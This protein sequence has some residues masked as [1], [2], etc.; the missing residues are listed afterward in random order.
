MTD[1]LPDAAARALIARVEDQRRSDLGRATRTLARGFAR[2][3]AGASPAARGELWRLRGHVL[4]AQRRAAG[5]VDA[6]LRAERWFARARQTRERGRCAIGLVDALMYLGRYRAAR[7]AA[8]RGRAA[9]ERAGDRAACARLLNNEGNLL[10]RLDRPDLALPVYRRA[11]RTLAHAGDA[12]GAAM[13][14][15][16]LANCLSLVGRLKESRASYVRAQRT[17]AANGFAV[18]ALGAGYNLAYLDFL[19]HRH[20][21]AL[22]GLAAVRE[23]AATRG[24]PALQALTSLD[25]AEILL[26]LNAPHD[27]LDEA[28]RAMDAF[29][30]LGMG[31]ERAK[32]ETFAALAEFRLGRPA[33]ARARLEHTLAGFHAEGNRVWMGEVLVGLATVWWSEGT[34]RAARALLAAA[35]RRFAAAGD[36][37]RE[38]GA[39]ALLARAQ[40]AC[41]R[42]ESAR[43]T[44]A[45]LRPRLGRRASPRVRHL[46]WAAAAA[47]ARSRGDRAAARRWLARAARES[48]RLAARIL[49]EQWR[50]T[51]WGDW[52]WPHQELATLEMEAGDFAAALEALERGRGRALASPSARAA[53][54]PAARAWAASRLARDRERSTRTGSAP[55]L[56][57]PALA[58][59]GSRL[60]DRPLS[61][62]VTARALCRVLPPGTVLVDYLLHGG[63]LSALVVRREGVDAVTGLASE[64]EVQRLMHGLLFGLRSAAW[65]DPGEEAVDPALAADLEALASQVLWPVL[66]RTGLPAALAVVPAGPLA[67]VPWP[68]L[69]LPDG[70]ALCQAGPLAVVPG[71]RLGLSL[72][73]RRPEGAPL[74]VAADAGELA[75]VTPETAR[76][77]GRFPHA[78]LLTGT[79]ATVGHFLAL[80]RDAEWIHFAGHGIYVPDSPYQSGLRLQDRWLLADEIAELSLS[81]RWVAL[82][83]CQTARALV[84]PGEE[85]FGLARTL[86][87]AGAGA[88]LASQWDIED[89]AAARLMERVYTHLA[90]GAPLT[91][92]LAVA[93][94]ELRSAGAHP[95][96]WAGFVVL[97]GPGAEAGV[98][99]L[100]GAVPRRVPRMSLHS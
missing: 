7:R 19:E 96:T 39:L 85:W 65:R 66:A 26:R 27:A 50:A 62:G 69:A 34:P 89:R 44:L 88:V 20:E 30:T 40:L 31:Y 71:L 36:R 81:A 87:L 33:A 82:S 9:L 53:L 86:L 79:D 41:G 46:A 61:G 43:R 84:R 70:R 68:A 56:A 60:L 91:R 22:S 54:P 42:T 52:G 72:G 76:I 35:A 63:S 49:D 94:A 32:A 47:L 1:R 55:A 57:A 5:A 92:A 83:A 90:G 78:R 25:S 59:R 23:E 98:G 11:H 51:F 67:R 74:I 8:A 80:S 28:R 16:N 14:E 3:V 99:A 37:E 21:R 4:R 97:T 17:L 2:A 18:D 58:I 93:Q 10:H 15:G 6:Y 73:Y 45:R 100:H 38:G 48:E 12:R 13:I 64:R 75:S 24:A 95:I 77:L 29:A